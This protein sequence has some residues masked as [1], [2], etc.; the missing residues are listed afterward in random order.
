[1]M[2]VKIIALD[3]DDTL[4]TGKL[5]IS[6]RTIHA[7]QN[8]A[9]HGIYIT[10]ASGRTDDA[11][12][13]FVRCLDL[14]G[15]EQGRYIIGQN[16]SLLFDLHTRLP[17]F[18]KKVP[19]DILIHVYRCAKQMNLA[20]E[21]YSPGSIIVPYK[22][23][24][25]DI[26]ASLSKLEIKVE[27][28]FETLLQKGHP[29]ILVPGEPEQIQKL[30]Q[31]LKEEIGYKCVIF[32]SKPYFLEVLPY[33]AGK[34]EA[35]E[36]LCKKLGIKREQTMAFGDSM[37]DESLLRYTYHSVAMCNGLPEIQKI[38]RYTTN[39]SNDQDGIADFLEK[40]VLTK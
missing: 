17:I 7:I 26:D 10:I 38:A 25:S 11:I 6:D 27:D 3:L 13:P 37:N 16:G 24:W 20:C 29:K 23:K 36:F 33:Q 40:N 15:T 2:D 28:D 31:Q 30:Y 18:L 1:M 5:T 22:N 39:F 19:G 35:L 8:C 14:A 4:L 9:S 34:G 32:T 12:L 21:V